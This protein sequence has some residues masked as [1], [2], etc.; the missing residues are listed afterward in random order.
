MKVVMLIFYAALLTLQASVDVARKH[1]H[2]GYFSWYGAVEWGLFAGV[3]T[4]TVVTWSLRK[5]GNS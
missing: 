4:V 3:V 1:S 2:A 5:K